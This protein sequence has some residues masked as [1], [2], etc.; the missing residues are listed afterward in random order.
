ME[1]DWV[2][3]KDYRRPEHWSYRKLEDKNRQNLLLN[4]NYYQ[5]KKKKK[6]KLCGQVGQ[7]EV[8]KKKVRDR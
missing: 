6:S 4:W 2:N 3:D 8:H 1:R 7:P 5:I